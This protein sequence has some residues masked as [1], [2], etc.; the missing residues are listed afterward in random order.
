MSVASFITLEELQALAAATPERL[1]KSTP[2]KI[3]VSEEHVSLK[4]SDDVLVVWVRRSP[5]APEP[6]PEGA[7]AYMDPKEH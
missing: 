1:P 3:E 5:R 2:V 7:L 4:D 6:L